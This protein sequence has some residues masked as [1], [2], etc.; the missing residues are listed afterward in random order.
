MA[1]KNKK[2]HPV[3]KDRLHPRNKHRERYDFDAL[4][5]TTPELAQYVTL[6]IYNDQ[7]IDFFNPAAVL[8]LNQALLKHYYGIDEWNIPEGYLCPPIPGRADYIHNIAALLGTSANDVIPVGPAIKCLDIGVGANCVYPIIGNNEYGWSFVGADVDPVSVAS[9][10]N[11]VDKNKVLQGNVEIRLQNHPLDIF[12]GIIGEG[13][14]FDVTICNPPFH[15]SAEDAAAGTLRK[16][17]N[18]QHKKVTKANLN[19][20]GQHNELWCEGG[21][22]AFVR[23]MILESKK[24]AA[25]C[26]WFSTLIS[27]Q[28]NLQKAYDQLEV[29]APFDVRT[30]PM[31]QGNKSS[32]LI[33][34]TFQSKEAQAKWVSARWK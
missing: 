31:G 16:L 13:E 17:S 21:E 14:R 19:F 11:I 20:G 9:A 3:T 22:S 25:S 34:W 15:A 4:I 12:Y 24:F 33:A 6:N 32:R 1:E 7:S 26:L 2:E 8:C 27:K 29:L 30:I 10:K 23:E 5:A 18:L 28:T